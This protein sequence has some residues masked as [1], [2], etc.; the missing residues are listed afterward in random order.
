M[1]T[2]FGLV[3][4]GRVV[5]GRVVN[6]IPYTGMVTPK[7]RIWVWRPSYVEAYLWDCQALHFGVM[8]SVVLSGV[9]PKRFI[10]VGCPL[11]YYLRIPGAT[12]SLLKNPGIMAANLKIVVEMKYR[13]IPYVYA[14]AKLASEQGLPMV[15]ALLVEYPDDP[16]TWTIDDAYLFG[17]NI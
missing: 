12:D 9:L 6:G 14:Q 17:T 5:S 11:A 2:S 7:L 4:P 16:G 8:I 10:G 15:R 1:N 13:L 3:V